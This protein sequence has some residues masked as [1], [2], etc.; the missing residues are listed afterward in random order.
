MSEIFK[1]HGWRKDKA[2]FEVELLLKSWLDCEDI[3]VISSIFNTTPYSDSCSGCQF[4]LSFVLIVGDDVFYHPYLEDQ[5]N[6]WVEMKFESS[7]R[8]WYEESILG[9]FNQKDWEK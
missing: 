9:K 4:I 5:E 2:V 7:D 3:Q 6:Y 1:V 8:K